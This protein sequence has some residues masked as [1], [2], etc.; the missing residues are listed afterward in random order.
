MTEADLDKALI[1]V[2]ETR[3][4]LGE[5]D[6]AGATPWSSYGSDKL[7]SEANQALALKAAQE[8]IVLLKNEKAN[9]ANDASPLLPISTDKSVA[10]IGP[11]ANQIMLGDYSGTPTYTTTPLR[12]FAKKMNF[13]VNDGA[14]QAE[15]FDEAVVSKRGAAKNKGADNLENTAPGDIFLYKNV[16]FGDGCASFEMACGAKSTGLGQISFCLDSK[17]ATP[18]LTLDNLDTGGWTKWQTVTA[19]VDKA[20]INGTHDLYVKFSGSNS[21]VGNYDYFKFYDPEVNPLEDQGPLYMVQTSSAVNEKATD[22]MIQ[23]AVA[24]AQKADYVVF[25]GGTDYSKP[26]THETGTEGHDRWVITLPG[27]QADV[28]NALRNANPNTIVVLECP[29]F[30]RQ[31]SW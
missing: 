19:S 8:S 27:N 1:R 5:F 15:N 17:D 28:I 6:G 22:A 24:A 31:L 12:A 14:I 10:L 18:F 4:A 9:A 29:S 25:V 7:E 3:F 23:R 26:D 20:L 21:Y 16:N 11:Y 13:T 2:L 30:S